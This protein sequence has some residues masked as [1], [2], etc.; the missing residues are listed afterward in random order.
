MIDLPKAYESK[1]VEDRIYKSWKEGSYFT[2]KIDHARQ[3]FT[4]IMPPPNVTGELHIGH[5]LTATLEDIMIRWHRMLGDPTLWLPGVDH[6]GIATQVVVEKELARQ[7]LDRH[8]IGREEFLK[9]VWDWV[10]K[11]RSAITHQHE[12]L[13]ASCDWSRERFTLDDGPVKAVKTT[14]VNLYNKGLI[15][16]GERIINWCPRCRTALS[17]L[18]VQNKDIASNLWHMRYPFEDGSGYITVATTRPETY[19]GDAAVAVNPEDER[20]TNLIGKRVI[21]PFINRAIPVIGD[22]AIDKEFGTGM[23]K[24][25]PA[26][27]PVDFEISQRHHLPIIHILNPDA[28]LNDN[29]G[30]YTGLDRFEA[31]KRVVEDFTKEGLMEKIEP[32]SH[33]VPHCFRCS[34]IIEPEVS[35]QWFVRIAPL[36]EPAATAVRDGRIK[37]LPE[38]FT[39]IYLNWMD[40]IRDWCISR[41][42]WWGHRIPVWYCLSCGEMIVSTETP[43]ACPKC[44]GT[45]LEQDPD[46]LDT[47]FSSGLWPHS[48]LGWPDQTEDLR[49]FYPTSVMETGYDIL[50]FW[51]ARMIMLGIENTGDAPFHTVYL[52]GLIRDENGEKMSKMKGNVL[53]PLTAI[54]Q[55]GCDALRFALT[56]GTAPGND[57]NMGAH[58]MEAGRNFANKLWNAGRFVLKALEAE[59][60]SKDIFTDIGKYLTETEDRWIVSRFNRL[61]GEV[62]SL[63]KDFQFGEAEKQIHDFL[64]GEYCDWYIEIS[65]QRL[66]KAGSPLPVLTYVLEAS[67]RLLHPFMPFITEELWQNMKERLPQ[68]MLEAPALIV[69]R[70]PVADGKVLNNRAEQVMEAVME[71]IR[72]IRNTRAEYKVDTGRWVESFIYADSLLEDIRAR[73]DIIEM[74]A[75]TRPLNILPR[76][77]R[78]AKNEKT[79][80]AVLRDAEVIVPLAGMIDLN[81]EKARL[82]KEMDG[83]Q[84]EIVRLTQRLEDG[85]FI[86]KAPS[87]VVEKEKARLEE[88]KSKF[89]RMQAELQQLG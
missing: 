3:P 14:F 83:L 44:G 72:S 47:W 7:G 17:D 53:N 55:Y 50:F 82:S 76:T 81:A 6:A 45:R 49:Y 75:R 19:L 32:Y 20:Y 68:G 11:S 27:D 4:I 2:P 24:V 41:Q 40:N 28:T 57:I 78:P 52:H 15:Y 60:A 86:G 69:A 80:V 43:T 73:S 1:Q 64:W 9:H 67:L 51:V 22:E 34:T 65:K 18:E 25:T 35:K 12:R 71:I 56:T 39:R 37:I 48:T 89:A 74:L 77:S 29:A 63:L 42:L 46:V 84:N 79:L 10:K 85:Q 54:D 13:G 66:G 16:R 88:Y 21:L 87:T 59:P 26:H 5:A 70:Y 31:R 38:R 8:Q 61:V 23:V 30:P 62:D 33:A 36:A 58:R